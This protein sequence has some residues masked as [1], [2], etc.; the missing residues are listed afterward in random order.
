[1]YTIIILSIWI[2][3]N[4]LIEGSWSLTKPSLHKKIPMS[5]GK[6]LRHFHSLSNTKRK[7]C[8]ESLII[9]KWR[10]KRPICY[11]LFKKANSLC[12]IE[13]IIV[14]GIFAYENYLYSLKQWDKIG[15]LLFS[16]FEYIYMCIVYWRNMVII[17]NNIYHFLKCLNI[18]A[19]GT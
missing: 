13:L 8:F 6:I 16:I 18:E 12:W 5:T 19:N 10:S 3:L 1:M 7:Q 15:I 9:I 4:N 17:W 14:H 11:R 2:S